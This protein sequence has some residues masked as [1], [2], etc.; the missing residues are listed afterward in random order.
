ML[1]RLLEGRKDGL[2]VVRFL[3]VGLIQR[4]N[5]AVEMPAQELMVAIQQRAGAEGG[6]RA[7]QNRLFYIAPAAHRQNGSMPARGTDRLLA[8]G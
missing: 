2:K 5:V 1:R 6:R 3:V 7:R 8:E 4:A